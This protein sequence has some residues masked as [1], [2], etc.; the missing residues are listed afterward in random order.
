[1][2]LFFNGLFDCVKRRK[3][4]FTILLLLSV[5]AIVLGVIAAVNFGGG[6]FAVDIS[7][8][9]YIRFLKGG[10]FMSMLFGLMFSLLV[11]FVVILI[12]YFK[13]FLTPIGILFYLYLV[14]SQAVIFMSI[15]LI[16]GILNCIIFVAL[17]LVYSLL[18][19]TLFLFVLCELANLCNQQGYFKSC[20]S[21]R[22][23]KVL[24]YLLGLIIIT[25]LFALV[26]AILK[27]YVI[28]LIF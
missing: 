12:C 24:L 22:E 21:L 25:F 9:A 10:G 6:V 11:F 27:N 14:Y 2:R 5:F 23:S 16:Y 28:L 17:L 20:F 8:I 19:W 3:G 15:I 13:H 26:L 7:N 4:Y 18:V 1:M